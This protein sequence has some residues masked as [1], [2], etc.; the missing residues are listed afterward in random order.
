MDGGG[1]EDPAASVAV[2]SLPAPEMALIR[3]AKKESHPP[4]MPAPQCWFGRFGSRSAQSLAF[5]GSREK[6][7]GPSTN[8]LA[9]PRGSS[10]HAMIESPWLQRGGSAQLP[11]P[12]VCVF[13]R[14]ILPLVASPRPQPCDDAFAEEEKKSN[15][16][17]CE[18][19]DASMP[20]G[21]LLFARRR[22]AAGR[23][24]LLVSLGRG[25][26]DKSPHHQ[27]PTHLPAPCLLI[28][29]THS[30][31]GFLYFSRGLIEDPASF[32]PTTV[33]R[34]ASTEPHPP[35]ATDPDVH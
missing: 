4:E 5:L 35:A 34:P 1:V 25:G 16:L 18:Q 6:T 13:H 10:Q 30:L 11:F 15:E 27:Q 21:Q 22:L 33:L 14:K 28:S 23:G 20:D 12:T 32:R 19:E 7:P 31:S 29:H 8:D 9:G 2:L 17:T 24:F 3:R 26:N